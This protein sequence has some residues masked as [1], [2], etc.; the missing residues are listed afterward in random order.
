MF[1]FTIRDLL[2]LMVVVALGVS[3]FLTQSRMGAEVLR[4]RATVLHQETENIRQQSDIE[5]YKVQLRKVRDEAQAQ[6]E[7][8][9][10]QRLTTSN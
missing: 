8:M 3:W 2:W 5:L 1:R 9:T 10:R 6:R 7:A 4:L